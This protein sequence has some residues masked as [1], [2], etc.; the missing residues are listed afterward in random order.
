MQTQLGNEADLFFNALV[1][2]PPISIRI[3]PFKQTSDI[4]R[5]PSDRANQLSTFN[6]QLSTSCIPWCEDGFYFS[7]RP[8]FIYDPLFHAGTYYVQEASS[9]FAGEVARRLLK[10]STN[11]FVL[12]AAAAPG[13]KSTHLHSVLN[14]RGCLISNEVI[15]QRN[16]VL[17]ENIWKWGVSNNVITQ[18]Q[19][20]EFGQAGE[21]FDLILLD[22]PCSGEGLFRRD[23]D[24]CDEWSL[25]SVAGCALRQKQLIEDVLPSLKVGGYLIYS[26]CTY[27]VEEN[28]DNVK[29]AL[30][31]FP[32][33]PIDIEIPDGVVKTKHGYQFYPHRVKG[34][35]FFISVLRKTDYVDS[36]TPTRSFKQKQIQPVKS[37]PET[38]DFNYEDF[39]FYRLNN[40]VYAV[41]TFVARHI[42]KFDSFNIKS[43][44]TP[45]FEETNF[46]NIPHTALALHADYNFHQATST[47]SVQAVDLDFENALS[48]LYGD[49][50]VNETE[51]KQGYALARFEKHNLG[52]IKAAG[53]RWNNLYPHPWRIRKRRSNVP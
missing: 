51:I 45:L 42:Q 26:T 49:A 1:E 9:M 2:P 7:E 34:E 25:Q 43:I 27:A 14:K 47:G 30:Q 48:Y 10:D 24:A 31:K 46:R 44:G 12:D 16:S 20:F 35:G 21:M 53:N 39:E 52:W 29:Q 28:D 18:Q 6:F 8:S 15:S 33:E 17:Q 4:R 13:G 32:L 19:L 40:I 5:Q 11:P 41:P 23:P 37:L 36:K 50:L 22:A 38:F 3:N